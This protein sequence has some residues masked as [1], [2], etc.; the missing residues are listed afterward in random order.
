MKR[1]EISPAALPPVGQMLAGGYYA[2]RIYFDGAEYAVIDSAHEI[3][4]QWWD[5]TG[6]RPNI[7]GAQFYEDGKS[8]TEAMAEAGSAVAQKVLR[9]VIRGTGGW[10]I[11]SI[12]ELELMRTNLCQLPDW[13]RHAGARRFTGIH[14]HWSST[15]RSAG[16][17]YNLFMHPWSPPSSN[18]GKDEKLVRPVKAIRIKPEAFIH[19]PATDTAT[20][21][22]VSSL[23]G[24]VTCPAVEA[25][26]ERF[27]NED[28]GRFYGRTEEL[29]AELAR[30]GAEARP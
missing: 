4:A 25:V 21:V 6:P 7:R 14:G 1:R 5:R 9:M 26:I 15:Q 29:V 20:N 27:V 10:H 24:L 30:I 8:N 2:G 19:S 17:A 12:R 23:P 11:P 18:W 28:T 13:E 22:A 3:N 16:S